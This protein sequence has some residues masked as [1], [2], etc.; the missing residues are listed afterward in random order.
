[1]FEYCFRTLA[2]ILVSDLCVCERAQELCERRG[3]RSGFPFPN[4]NSPYGLC[5]RGPKLNERAVLCLQ[6]PGVCVCV[7][8]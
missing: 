2:V 6:A 3:G 4:T 5:G 7:C 1:M 8:V